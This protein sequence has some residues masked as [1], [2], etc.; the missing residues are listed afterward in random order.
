MVVVTTAA[1]SATDGHCTVTGDTRSANAH[2]MVCAARTRTRTAVSFDGDRAC[3]CD[4]TRDRHTDTGASRPAG[5]CASPHQGHAATPQLSIRVQQ[6]TKTA[7]RV[8]TGPP[9]INA[10][11]PC[12]E[13]RVRI[14]HHTGRCATGI[15]GQW[16]CPPSDHD[17]ATAGADRCGVPRSTHVES[18]TATAVVVTVRPISHMASRGGDCKAAQLGDIAAGLEVDGGTSKR[19]P[20]VAVNVDISAIHLDRPCNADGAAAGPQVNVHITC[21][22][23]RSF[24]ANGQTTQVSRKVPFGRSRKRARKICAFW[25]NHQS[26]RPFELA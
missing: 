17:V 8:G 1:P 18:H 20:Q 19:A 13:H 9:H 4:G 7:T 12:I 22:V 24:F 15:A 16:V 21:T 10:A 5:A 26:A 23:G 14:H 2:T 25:L 6:H 11:R 3:R